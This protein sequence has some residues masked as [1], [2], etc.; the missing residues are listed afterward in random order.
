MRIDYGRGWWSGLQAEVYSTYRG[1]Y[2]SKGSRLSYSCPE[3][4]NKEVKP[5]RGSRRTNGSSS[6][7]QCLDVDACMCVWNFGYVCVFVC[8]YM[9]VSL[10]VSEC[11]L[12]L[13]E[14]VLGYVYTRVVT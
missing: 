12:W 13:C 14:K 1:T 3:A 9:T 4:E 6:I 5:I 11:Y 7:Q 10:C 2:G 8:V